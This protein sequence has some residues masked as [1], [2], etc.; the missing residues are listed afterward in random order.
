M[1][2]WEWRRERINRGINDVDRDRRRKEGGSEGM[3]RKERKGKR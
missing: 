1:K 3:K 2:T